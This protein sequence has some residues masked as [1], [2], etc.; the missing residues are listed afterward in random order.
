MAYLL[1][2][3]LQQRTAIKTLVDPW[4]SQGEA[5]TSLLVYGEIV[6]YFLS[7]PNSEKRITQLQHAINVIGALNVSTAI[8]ERYAVIR[9]ELRPPHGPGIIGDVDTLIAATA[10]EHGLTLVTADSDFERVPRLTSRLLP[11]THL[12]A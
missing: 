10:I 12:K 2:A 11:R 3:Y 9:R 6:E 1:Q 8:E 4:V 5:R 7:L